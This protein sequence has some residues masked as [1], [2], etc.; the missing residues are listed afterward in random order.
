M[1][2]ADVAELFLGS[3]EPSVKTGMWLDYMVGN[4]TTQ[5]GIES[6]RAFLQAGEINMNRW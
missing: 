6:V 1:T 3:T 4:Q 5:D 2:T